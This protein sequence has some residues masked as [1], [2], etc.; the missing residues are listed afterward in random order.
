VPVI[1][2]TPSAVPD[3]FESVGTIRAAQSAQ[4]SSQIMGNVVSV[5]V[6]EGDMVKRGQML[7]VIDD[8]QLRAGLD[9]AQAAA[10]GADH[11]A[12]AAEAECALA[13]S[14]MKRFQSLFD[15][16][17][18]SPQEMDEVNAR[19]Q[20]ASARRETARSGQA[21][22]Q[23][24][25]SQARTSLDYTRIRA[26]F[27][28]V[29]SD[30]RADPGVL[31][32]P[33]MPLLTVEAAERFRLEANVDESGLRFVHMGQ[34]VPVLLDA[35]GNQPLPGAVVQMVPA[36]DPGSR[37][38]LVK[39]ELPANPA[40]RSGQFGRAQFAK[41]ERT[42]LLVPRNA[43]IS[44]GQLQAVYVIDQNDVAGLR[45][46]TLGSPSGDRVEVLSGLSQ[47][48]KVI[49]LPGEQDLAGKKIEVR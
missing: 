26:P 17:S 10:A 14:T 42:S 9:R 18:V 11:E 30:R 45:Y 13:E 36:A 29:V 41:G 35:V 5:K 25:L 2:L 3:V 32:S 19:Y 8:A 40:I 24:A 47:G 7:A 27:D 38:F 46:V 43:I 31:A 44:R 12:A 1:T 28:G 34:T 16:K 49:A 39:I 4:I 37:S 48:D 15:K 21:Q 23:A 20:A 22:A 33:G 6:H